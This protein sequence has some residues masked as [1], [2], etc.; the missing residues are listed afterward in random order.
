[1]TTAPGGVRA[2]A[3][4]L[5]RGDGRGGT[6]LPVLEGEGPL[7]LRRTRGSGAEA[8]VM[9]VGAMS[10]P[11]GGDHFTV[12]VQARSGARLRV[13]SAAATLA[14]PGQDKAG[15]RYDVRL[16]V[17]DGA[18]LCWLPEQLISAGGSDLRLTTSVDL[19]A[20]AR[21]LLRE[22]QVLGRAGEE[23]GR[24]TSR[25]TVRIDGRCVLDQELG[26]GPGAPGGWDG[27]AGLAGHRAVGQVVVV[28]PEF[29]DRPPAGC[30][31]EEGAAVM[32]LAGPAA[33]VSAVAPDGLRLRRLL[34]GAL[35]SL[36]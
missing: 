18:E 8:R 17:D 14:L 22:E 31:Y 36:D 32:P 33:L 24:L 30:V 12:D 29:A 2:S 20:G 13:G 10:G 15:A 35:A 11:L 7:A 23:P 5:A 27:P 1:M 4:V 6:A 21:L 28:R 16:T 34:D 26:C 25:L 9:L 3:R 19:A